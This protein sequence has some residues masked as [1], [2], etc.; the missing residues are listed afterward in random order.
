MQDYKAIIIDNLAAMKAIEARN[1]HVFKAKAYQKVINQLKGLKTPISNLD[2]LNGLDGV[3]SGIKG[4]L[5]AILEQ[6]DLNAAKEELKNKDVR[7]AMET[8]TQVMGIGEVKARELVVNHGVMTIDALKAHA[9]LLNHKQQLGLM[10]HGDFLKRI[11]RKEMDRHK[12]F[13]D[14]I[15]PKDRFM[16][17]I[18]GSYRRGMA[19]SGDIDVL[20]TLADGIPDVG[21]AFQSMINV[22][23]SKKYLV[24]DFG[25]GT[26]KYLGIARLPRFKTYRRIDIMY[27]PRDRYA[28][29]LFYFTGSQA[30]NI[31]MRNKALDQG[32]S[33]SEH[34]LKHI[35]GP[36]KGIFV[37]S[38]VFAIEQDIFDFLNVPYVCPKER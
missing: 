31:S 21:G 35:R 16:Y 26:E 5:K 29:A 3:G 18:A 17:E 24:G 33:L 7:M 15:I 22:L 37:T 4:K 32:Y 13:I 11:P 8:M 14:E 23:K 28:F 12:I 20:V 6:G 30:F 34:G 36:N 27:I 25:F 19:S 9:D 38:R 2:D 10:H 1:K